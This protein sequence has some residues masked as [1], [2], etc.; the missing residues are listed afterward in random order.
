MSPRINLTLASYGMVLQSAHHKKN[1]RAEMCLKQFSIVQQQEGS[2][3]S[4]ANKNQT[5]LK[6]NFSTAFR[7]LLVFLLLFFVNPT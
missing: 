6:E 7:Q 4:T 1:R 2:G 3:C 5:Y